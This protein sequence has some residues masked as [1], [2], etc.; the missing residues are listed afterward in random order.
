MVWYVRFLSYVCTHAAGGLGAVCSVNAAALLFSVV[1][2]Q[3]NWGV[4]HRLS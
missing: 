4:E 2:R 1:V 3:G